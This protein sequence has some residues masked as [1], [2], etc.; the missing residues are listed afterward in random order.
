MI[1]HFVNILVPIS[2]HQIVFNPVNANQCAIAT[3]DGISVATITSSGVT[4]QH[5]I[6]NCIISQF[7]SVACSMKQ[8]SSFGGAVY[9]GPDYIPGGTTLNEPE[10]GEQLNPGYTGDV[11]WSM[12]YPSSIYYPSGGSNP[13]LTRSEDM[14]VTP[15]PTFMSTITNSHI[16]SN[17]LLGEL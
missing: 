4:F 6:K 1:I 15:S 5:M 13:P 17:Q 14:G 2:Q 8:E 9:V 7:N 16:C 12:I 10:N 11:A 3:D